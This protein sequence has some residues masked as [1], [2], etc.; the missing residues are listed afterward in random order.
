MKADAGTRAPALDSCFPPRIMCKT[1]ILEV[2]KA[3]C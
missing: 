1:D 3:Y 2:W